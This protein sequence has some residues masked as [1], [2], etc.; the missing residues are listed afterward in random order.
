MAALRQTL[1]HSTF[2]H[3]NKHIYEKCRKQHSLRIKTLKI[4]LNDLHWCVHTHFFLI[5]KCTAYIVLFMH[6]LNFLLAY[7]NIAGQSCSVIT[8]LYTYFNLLIFCVEYNFWLTRHLNDQSINY[9][10]K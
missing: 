10:K 9:L 5:I 6:Y 4:Q 1:K 7:F 2:A 3:I 8:L